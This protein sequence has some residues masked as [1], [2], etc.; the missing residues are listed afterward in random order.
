M[1]IGSERGEG[2][3]GGERER[4]REERNGGR[5]DGW[6]KRGT[7]AGQVEEGVI[8]YRFARIPPPTVT[9]QYRAA[10]RPPP[11]NIAAG[12]HHTTPPQQKTGVVCAACRL[13]DEY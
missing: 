3:N 4:S 11:V 8:A 12:T 7:D 10:T 9:P 5:R 6:R 1:N 2:G 13:C